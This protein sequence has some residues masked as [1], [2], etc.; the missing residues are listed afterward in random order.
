MWM[1]NKNA[2]TVHIRKG[3]FQGDSF[4]PLWFHLALDPA[5]V[6]LY[7][8]LIYEIKEDYYISY[9]WITLNYMQKLKKSYIL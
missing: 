9:T 4:S 6:K 8:S 1:N 5:P 7:T 2:G 3:I